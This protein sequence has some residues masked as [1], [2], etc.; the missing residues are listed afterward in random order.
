MLRGDVHS[1]YLQNARF[2]QEVDDLIETGCH[3]VKE[4]YDVDLPFTPGRQYSRKE[5][6]R[7]LG[8]PRKWTSTVYGY[9]VDRASGVCPIFVTLHKSADI[10]ESTAY[11]DELI[12]RSSMRWY[13]RSRRTLRSEEVRTIV[14]NEVDLYVFVKK[15]DAE[16]TE[17]YFLGQAIAH[18]AVQSTMPDQ[19]GKSLDVVHMDLR[20]DQPIDRPLFDYFHPNIYG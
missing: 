1:S 20:F 2:A 7:N 17:F 8:W 12:D 15:D 9:K 13:T 4:R 11:K 10:A 6:M 3:I 16:G 14:G 18:D 5:V 19:H